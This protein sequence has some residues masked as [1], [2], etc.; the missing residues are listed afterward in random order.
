MLRMRDLVDDSSKS[1]DSECDG[2]ESKSSFQAPNPDRHHPARLDPEMLRTSLR[3]SLPTGSWS[4]PTTGLDT[5]SA[6]VPDGRAKS[7]AAS[8]TSDT[9][10]RQQL[11]EASKR[12]RKRHKDEGVMLLSEIEKLQHQVTLLRN[13][14]DAPDL[15]A[16]EENKSACYENL[17]L[18]R[19][20]QFLDGKLNEHERW[21]HRIRSVMLAAPLFDFAATHH[22][23]QASRPD[24]RHRHAAASAP[25]LVYLDE[26]RRDCEHDSFSHVLVTQ[27]MKE[28]VRLAS[29]DAA[30]LL[31]EVTHQSARFQWRHVSRGW[32]TSTTSNNSLLAFRCERHLPVG[33]QAKDV[34]FKLWRSLQR[35]DILRTFVPAI[36][37]S[38]LARKDE[39]SS[40]TRRLLQLAPNGQSYVAVTAESIE[41]RDSSSDDM[42]AWQISVDVLED[43]YLWRLAV[44]ATR[45]AAPHAPPSQ[46]AGAQTS[47]DDENPPC[48]SAAAGRF[49]IALRVL[50]DV[51][52]GASVEMAGCMQ[53]VPPRPKDNAALELLQYLVAL[54]PVYE[55]L[56]LV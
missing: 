13:K 44:E 22:S 35:D 39:S 12:C 14:L 37:E 49:T 24:H 42:E 19:H 15:P 20:A 38:M 51:G 27:R 26:W 52:G 21:L 41:L 18:K 4:S 53:V 47:D 34:A 40:I 36:Q 55:E 31:A 16:V 50:Q 29:Q 8:T 28:A 2:A 30:E 46:A 33:S 9:K 56:H 11:N 25:E 7:V 54:L 32:T 3:G 43:W 17:R 1:P 48:G 5:L 45:V 6:Q 10:R 23:R